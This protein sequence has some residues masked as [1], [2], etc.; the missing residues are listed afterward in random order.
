MK[1]ISLVLIFIVLI[2]IFII[3]KDEYTNKINNEKILRNNKE[4][5]ISKDI[6]DNNIKI[7]YEE[8]KFIKS[9]I[10]EKNN[11]KVGKNNFFI[12]SEVKSRNSLF[13]ITLYSKE[14]LKIKENKEFIDGVIKFNNIEDYFTIFFNYK[15]I[16]MADKLYMEVKYKDKLFTSSAFRLSELQSELLYILELNL[17][18]DYI[19]LYPIEVGNKPKEIKFKKIDINQTNKIIKKEI[20]NGNYNNIHTISANEF[21]ITNK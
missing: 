3:N 10:L 15:L 7:I 6:E 11:S 20:K 4:I 16:D 14:D 1:Y 21:N 13:E 12:I 9:N 8:K 17:I 18:D 2:L 5:S 19:D